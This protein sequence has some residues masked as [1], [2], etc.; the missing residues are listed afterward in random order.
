MKYFHFFL[1]QSCRCTKC[2]ICICVPCVLCLCVYG[3]YSTLQINMNKKLI[4]WIFPKNQMKCQNSVSH[5]TSSVRLTSNTVSVS[6]FLHMTRFVWNR[7][8]SPRFLRIKM[9]YVLPQGR[10]LDS[11]WSERNYSI[12]FIVTATSERVMPT[13]DIIYI[14]HNNKHCQKSPVFSNTPS[15]VFFQLILAAV[16]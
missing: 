11:D 5:G 7:R 3:N 14:K 10:I 13:P 16:T 8:E 12:V 6:P 15:C 9:S 2:V 4:L 1:P